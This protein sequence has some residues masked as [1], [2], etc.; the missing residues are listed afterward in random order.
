MP[1]IAIIGAG[2]SGLSLAHQLHADFDVTLFEK[3][4]CAGG[5][6]ASRQHD[7]SWFD[8]GA[9]FFTAKTDA[10]NDFLSPLIK[11]GVIQV[12]NGNFIEFKGEQIVRRDSWTTEYPHWVGCP[13]MSAIGCSL[14][15]SLQVNYSTLIS[16]TIHTA[17][18]WML[19]DD[20]QQT[21]GPYDWLVFSLPPQQIAAIT[22][23]FISFKETLSNY[24]M[25]G[26][27]ALMLELD[28]SIKLEFDAA[29]VTDTNISWISVNNSK[30]E[31]GNNTT[32]VVHSTNTWADSHQRS[33][34]QQLKLQMIDEFCRV[35]KTQ[36]SS[37][38]Y[39]DIKRWQYANITKQTGPDYLID[40][41]HHAAACGDWC[42]QG[43]VEAA[44]TS[45]F[46]LAETINSER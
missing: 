37:I 16:S 24:E 12:W 14:S 3:H 42:I 34:L 27:C 36:A 2:L 30:P 7:K 6:M 11:Q 44:F 22:P 8:H 19:T 33:D 23:P 21:F 39:S 26:C 13:T 25:R 1:T 35:T 20:N 43:R 32:V 29:V 17:Q 4:Y 31:R 40:T 41:K 46:Q 18:G 15:T 28:T 9:Q 38:T 45:A 10:F 5:R